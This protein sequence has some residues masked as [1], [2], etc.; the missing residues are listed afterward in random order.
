[1]KFNDIEIGCTRTRTT[2]K[3]CCIADRSAVEGRPQLQQVPWSETHRPCDGDG[4]VWLRLNQHHTFLLD[5][6]VEE[7]HLHHLFSQ[8]TKLL[9]SSYHLPQSLTHLH[10]HYHYHHTDL[11]LRSHLQTRQRRHPC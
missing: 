10:H 8:V 4:S 2:E 1:M 6:V 11:L 7:P 5:K 3:T 9:S